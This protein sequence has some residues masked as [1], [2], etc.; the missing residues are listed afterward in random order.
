MLSV[1]MGAAYRSI[2]ENATA[3]W[4]GRWLVKPRKELPAEVRIDG[5]ALAFAH[6][7]G[8]IGDQI[9]RLLEPLE[10]AQLRFTPLPLGQACPETRNRQ[11]LNRR[12]DHGRD[13]V[14]VGADD[15]GQSLDHDQV[16]ERP[17]EDQPII[18]SVAHRGSPRL[19]A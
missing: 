10:L 19:G 14:L 9:E 8:D 4:S 13:E 16:G 12:A 18:G 17:F 11:T 6:G 2:T 15:L 7:P 5:V 1:A 3:V